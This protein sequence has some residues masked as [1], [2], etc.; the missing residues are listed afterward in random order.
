MPLQ[1]RIKKM[2]LPPLKFFPQKINVQHVDINC[3]QL[4]NEIKKFKENHK[5]TGR[6]Y[7]VHP[8]TGQPVFIVESEREGDECFYNVNFFHLEYKSGEQYRV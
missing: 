7:H 2:N 4:P 5:V 8:Q 1:E 3:P 6:R